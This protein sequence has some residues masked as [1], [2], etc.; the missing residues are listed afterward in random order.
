MKKLIIL[1]ALIGCS[2]MALFTPEIEV[3]KIDIPNVYEIVITGRSQGNIELEVMINDQSLRY[4]LR[5]GAL[6]RLQVEMLETLV[7]K[8]KD[9]NGQNIK[10]YELHKGIH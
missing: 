3:R 8:W 2:K 4:E 6:I 9:D 1:V 10:I 7:L 5:G